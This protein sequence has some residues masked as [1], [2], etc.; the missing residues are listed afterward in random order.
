MKSIP[1]KLSLIVILVLAVTTLVPIERALSECI[2]CP[3]CLKEILAPNGKPITTIRTCCTCWHP[4]SETQQDVCN[5]PSL[6]G[7]DGDPGE[8]GIPSG[9]AGGGGVPGF[10]LPTEGFPPGVMPGVHG[11]S[12]GSGSLPH[13]Q[14]VAGGAWQPV[15]GM[16]SASIS[17]GFISDPDVRLG[18]EFS[19]SVRDIT[20][21][22]HGTRVA[23]SR[24]YRHQTANQG[25]VTTD[26]GRNFHT[27][28]RI[29]AHRPTTYLGDDEVR[30]QLGNGGELRFV[31]PPNE[32]DY[33]SPSGWERYV[34]EAYDTDS[35]RLVDN[36]GYTFDFGEIDRGET[37]PLQSTSNLHGQGENYYYD[38]SGYLTEIEIDATR[39]ITITRDVDHTITEISDYL[40]PARTVEYTYDANTNLTA[41]EDACG[42]CG[43]IPSMNYGYDGSNRMTSIKDADNETLYT[44]VYDAQ[45]R[46]DYVQTGLNDVFDY[47]YPSATVF[48]ITDPEDSEVQYTFDAN[49][50][51]TERRLMM[52]SGTEDDIV[53]AYTYDADKYVDVVTL[54]NGT[55]IDYDHDDRGRL[56]CVEE[57]DGVDTITLFEATYE[58][59]GQ[60]E[61]LE[62]LAA[63]GAPVSYTYTSGLPT[64]ITRG[65]YTTERDYDGAGLVTSVTDPEDVE[66][67]LTRNTL[68]FVTEKTV[69]DI[70]AVGTDLTTEFEVD[71]LGQITSVETPL[72][73]TTTYDRNAAGKVTKI[74]TPE[75]IVT[76]FE[77]DDNG[78]LAEKRIM[79]GETALY[80]WGYTY[81][82]MGYLTVEEAPDSGT[83]TYEYDGNKRLTKVTDPAGLITESIY[84]KNGNLTET[85]K[86]N[87]SGTSTV[88]TRTY[89][90]LGN[91]LT[92]TDGEDNTTT[93]TYDDFSRLIK[94]TDALDHYT[95]YE[96]DGDSRR[97]VVKRY[98]SDDDLISYTK[99]T[100][101]SLGRATQVRTYADLSQDPPTASPDDALTETAYDGNDR[102]TSNK[103]WYDA[104]NYNETTYTYDG[105]G[106]KVSMTDPDSNTTEY[107]Y[108]LDG[109][110]TTVTD[111]R[112]KETT[113]TYD[114]DGRR[115]RV[116]NA[117]DDYTVTAYD[118]RGL[119][120]SVSQYNSSDTLLAKTTYTYDD[121]GRQTVVRRKSN[122]AGADDNDN[123]YVVTS[124]YTSGRLTTQTSAAGEDTTYTYDAQGRVT[125]VTYP[126]DSDVETTYDDAGRRIREVK[127]EKVGETT[128]TYRTDYTL[129]ALG[130]VAVITN[131]GPDG[132]FGNED[133]RTIEY[134]Y[135]GAGRRTSVT[136]EAGKEAVTTYD[137]LGRK[138]KVTEDANG[139]ARVTE[140]DYD[141]AG[142]MTTLTAYTDSPSTGQQ[143]TT[144]AYNGRGLQTGVTY[145][146]TGTVSMTYDAAGNM[147]QR[148][149][150]ESVVVVYTYDDANRLVDRRESGET[151]DVETYAYDGLGRLVTA[152]KGTT[153]N[154]DAVSESTFTY[155][156]L[157]RLTSEV[158]TIAEG[159]SRTI[160]YGY[161]KAGRRTSL[162]HTSS[163][164]NVAYAYDSR[165]R[166]TEIDVYDT[167]NSEWDE[168]ADYTWL[169][170][171]IDKRVT[172]CDY[173]GATK[174]QFKTEYERDGL[175]R[176]T[177]V[178]NEHITSDMADTG[179][180]ELGSFNYTYDAVANPLTETSDWALSHKARADR[181]FTYDTLNRLTQAVLTDSL[182]LSPP[183]ESKTT[184]Y[185]YDDLGNRSSHSYRGAASISYTHDDANRMTVVAGQSQDYDDAGNQTSGYSADRS[186]SYVYKYDHH[187]RLSEVWDSSETNRKA[188]FIYDALGRRIV[189]D[190]D[191]LD[192]TVQYFYDGV[193]EIADFDDSNTLLRRYVHG[194]SYVDERLMMY[195]ADTD[196]PYYYTL[197]RMYD[198]RMLVDRAGAVVERYMYDP[199][200]RPYVTEMPCRGDMNNNS[201]FQSN[202][203]A[204]A[205]NA[206]NATIWDP[207]ADLDDDGDVDQTDL[208]AYIAK[209]TL[210]N[211]TPPTVR[212]AFSDV[213]NPYMFQG[214]PHFAL[215]TT[216]S[217]TEAELML[218]DHRARFGDPV[219]GRWITRDPLWYDMHAIEKSP[220]VSTAMFPGLHVFTGS[221]DQ[222]VSSS[223]SSRSSSAGACH[224]GG[225]PLPSSTLSEQNV[226]IRCGFSSDA[227]SDEQSNQYAFA[228][229]APN[230]YADPSGLCSIVYY[231]SIC[232]GSP[233]MRWCYVHTTSCPSPPYPT[234][235]TPV[236]YGCGGASPT[237]N[238]CLDNEF[239][240]ITLH[241]PQRPSWWPWPTPPPYTTCSKF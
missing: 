172:T 175:L 88:E 236:V 141:R 69:V 49:G 216:A 188:A 140:F 169:G 233:P 114:D 37:I 34:L 56:V 163:G 231:C 103:V 3:E 42:T 70:D 174:P 26:F 159:T 133:D 35:Y 179:Y 180:E 130:R 21:P 193:N 155:D 154:A 48:S 223:R 32:S 6:G 95:E 186:T 225:G 97:T 224:P 9:G 81:N 202:D 226:A 10:G 117:V 16:E 12:S 204:R 200:G 158:Q 220:L 76:E 43:G 212:Q 38:A 143:D 79:D 46:V 84:D 178:I 45:N 99:I 106:R 60:P 210:W 98:N 112:D 167:V 78:R 68:G 160:S 157:S 105:A 39:S 241:V 19:F 144:Y 152:R 28:L 192:E 41:V 8:E 90:K 83:T 149:D 135:D 87:A 126:D 173:P 181:A 94:T 123:D 63:G 205:L 217:A 214:R 64:S 136:D 40:D 59:D 25:G 218:N 116:T 113:Y 80:A 110:L 121:A 1:G 11:G 36:N 118:D 50:Q 128:Y 74:T 137:A 165:D 195:D 100:Y 215:D 153:S 29:V 184:T 139:I 89:D 239:V 5:T 222:D 122:P 146:E 18:G 54:P 51:M 75:G 22:H 196:R 206:K 240:K 194:I 104:S 47:D 203:L 96:Y 72:G 108:N 207:R 138:T 134:A 182:D 120:T 208:D 132:T 82:R 228:R 237:C 92:V 185:A 61:S 183:G 161:D 227:T 14:I 219:I 213:G 190:N 187:N 171:A 93:H 221:S 150:E 62:S 33:S 198:V 191:V 53:Y 176:V 230:R 142:R 211:Q 77:Y 27:N 23:V 147:T 58:D 199:Y 156:A 124:T 166:C 148:T 164:L 170:S 177:K 102:V 55:T 101:V 2:T 189:Y 86:G 73:N 17:T 232:Q 71:D 109:N 67:T 85:K 57:S 107:E 234:I 115:I 151:T 127:H 66:T 91:L 24:V 119:R 197:D 238:P 229:S 129:D 145:E 15:D 30:V 52:E 65:S 235:G 31:L 125:E 162:T 168:L 13:A 201:R 131:Q 209:V 20:W 44:I 7:N 111:P 4:D